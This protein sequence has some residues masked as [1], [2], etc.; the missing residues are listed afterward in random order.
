VHIG[1][2][3]KRYPF[4]FEQVTDSRR[5]CAG[6]RYDCPSLIQ[7]PKTKAQQSNDDLNAADIAYATGKG[8]P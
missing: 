7:R 4:A 1:R 5:A 3:S 8:P 2:C 6:D